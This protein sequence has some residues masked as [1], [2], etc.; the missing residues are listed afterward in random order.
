MANLLKKQGFYNSLILYAGTALGFLNLVILFQRFLTIQEIGFFT[1]MIT[2]SLLYAQIS[3]FG[4]SNVIIRY[5]PYYRTDD[6]RHSGFVTFIVIWC[7][8]GFCVVTLLFVV[9]KSAV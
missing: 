3:S 5:F 7:A 6:K 4:I 8:V 2:T 9:F 1:L